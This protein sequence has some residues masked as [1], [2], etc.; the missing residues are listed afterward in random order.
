VLPVGGLKEKTAVHRSGIMMIIGPGANCMEI[1]ENVT[2]SVKTDIRFVYIENVREVLQ[3]F[4][5]EAISERWKDTL[6][7]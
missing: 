2:E 3:V 4:R 6:S 5:G 7:M 1:E